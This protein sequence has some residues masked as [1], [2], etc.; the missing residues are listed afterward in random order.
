MA[1]GSSA[2]WDI[3]PSSSLKIDRRFGGTYDH[4]RSLLGGGRKLKRRGGSH[5][6]MFV[7]CLK[8]NGPG[9]SNA[10]PGSK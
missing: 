10:R 8:E 3:T 6:E 9:T 4:A 2:F 7:A 5:E 1:V